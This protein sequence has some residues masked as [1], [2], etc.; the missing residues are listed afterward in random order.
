MR[1]N[2]GLI[3]ISIICLFVS[4]GEKD[5]NEN[6]ASEDK[7]PGNNDPQDGNNQGQPEG[8]PDNLVIGQGG[9]GL[10]GLSANLTAAPLI[11]PPV[12]KNSPQAL[13]IALELNLVEYD[14]DCQDSYASC[15]NGDSSNLERNMCVFAADVKCRFFSESGPT[16]IKQILG[17]VDDSIKSVQT[18][19]NEFL[20]CLDPVANK[21]G[22]EYNDEVFEKYKSVEFD[23]VFEGFKDKG[24]GDLTVDLGFNYAVSCFTTAE[25]GNAGNW[26]GF[27]KTVDEA[28]NKIFTV[29]NFGG[30]E[31]GRNGGVA[32]VDQDNNVNFWGIVSRSDAETVDELEQS[33]ALIHLKSTAENGHIELA[34]AGKNVGPDCKMQMITNGKYL[35]AKVNANAALKCTTDDSGHQP[36]FIFDACL[37]VDGEKI[38]T[39]DIS[40]CTAENL[41]EAD[42]TISAITGAT[43]LPHEIHKLFPKPE[44][45]PLAR[46]V[47]LPKEKEN[48]EE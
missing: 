26:G 1:L 41:T 45:I 10:E 33:N 3:L 16:Q 4:C 30:A 32:T 22:F 39:T 27:G 6:N 12:A 42:M 46:K 29:A 25:S 38:A 20:P 31:N 34:F 11:L 43:I 14:I 28:G 7:G 35:F 23:T 40:N 13:K 19:S 8:N 47:Y 48:T 5:G 44:G 36:N 37:K 21:D 2:K 15:P 9:K 18:K 24:G 17:N